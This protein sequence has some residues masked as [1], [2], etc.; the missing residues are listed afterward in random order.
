MNREINGAR[1]SRAALS[2]FARACVRT[3]SCPLSL[4]VVLHCNYLE[5]S[6]TSHDS[7]AMFPHIL[8]VF[9][10][11]CCWCDDQIVVIPRAGCCWRL[12]CGEMFTECSLIVCVCVVTCD[13]LF[14]LA[15][16]SRSN[17]PLGGRD[18]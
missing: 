2:R 16:C 10:C 6:Q 7:S 8:S 3:V 17:N 14:A 13:I 4:F 12:R 11:V 15:G 5:Q 1:R 9:V 18:D